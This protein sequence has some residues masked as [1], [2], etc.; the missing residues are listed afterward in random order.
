MNSHTLLRVENIAVV[1]VV[2]LLV[3]KLLINVLEV[4]I[5]SNAS[6]LNHKVNYRVPSKFKGS[7]P[8]KNNFKDSECG[9]SMKQRDKPELQ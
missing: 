9:N 6:P 2:S 1:S 5:G 3:Q 8:I 4:N 7:E